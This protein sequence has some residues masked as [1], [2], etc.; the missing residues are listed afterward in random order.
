[1]QYLGVTMG[2][3]SPSSAFPSGSTHIML[4]TELCDM[5]LFKLLHRNDPRR[6]LTWPSRVKLAYGIANGM[7]Y[8]HDVMD[9]RAVPCRAMPSRAGVT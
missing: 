6:P 7:A 2:K 1:M 3:L 9:V 8:L 5:D 4:V